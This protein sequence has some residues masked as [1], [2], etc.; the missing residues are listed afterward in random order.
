MTPRNSL[1]GAA[2]IAMTLLGGAAAQADSVAIVNPGFEAN[3]LGDGGF[4]VV[5]PTGW[6]LFSGSSSLGTFNPTTAQLVAPPEGTQVAYLN[7]FA[8][9]EQTLG[10]SVAAGDYVL[11]A[12]FAYRKD[13]CTPGP[14]T[15]T[16]LAGS[17]VLGSFTGGLLDGFSN[18]A[19]K[20]AFVNVLVAGDS[21]FIGAALGIRIEGKGGSQ[22]D[23]DN[24][25]LNFTPAAPVPLPASGLL[26][27]PA[28]FGLARLARRSARA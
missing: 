3:V 7:G 2:A 23:I 21:P 4:T 26:L 9:I 11:S 20:T 1:A 18:T 6:A 22:V 19:F 14:F 13:C 15:L 8:A 10:S 24:V 16:L 5:P 17:S 12:D 27:A 28:L 25:S